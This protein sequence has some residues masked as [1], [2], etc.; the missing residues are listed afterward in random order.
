VAADVI[1]H[2]KE[3]ELLLQSVVRLLP[4]ARA[5]LFSTPER[6]LWSGV[7]S[8]GPPRA[9]THVREWSIREFQ[10]FLYRAGFRHVSMGLTRSNDRT[11]DLN[12][13]LAACAPDADA[14]EPIT[15]A[16]IDYER[17]PPSH[18]ATYL[19]FARAARVLLRG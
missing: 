9:T 1:E 2:L 3:P 14:L 16:L 10:W 11:D 17:Q 15:E 4:M 19:R 7:R 5:V 8:M 6:E 12:T 13:I 18:G